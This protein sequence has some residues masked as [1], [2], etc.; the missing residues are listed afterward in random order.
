MCVK[1]VVNNMERLKE[2][3]MG[4]DSYVLNPYECRRPSVLIYLSLAT[5]VGIGISGGGKVI[6]L[7]TA[8]L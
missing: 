2:I 5:R 6:N 3:F 4:G 7:S 8:T 1:Y